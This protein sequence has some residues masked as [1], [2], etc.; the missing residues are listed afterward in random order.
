MA[1]AAME[2]TSRAAGA[3]QVEV[4]TSCPELCRSFVW[5]GGD[6]R[7]PEPQQLPV[8]VCRGA[9]NICAHA[10]RNALWGRRKN[11]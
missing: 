2:A 7:E 8:R 6:S 1:A 10:A 9:R 5:E 4:S 11:G 3:S